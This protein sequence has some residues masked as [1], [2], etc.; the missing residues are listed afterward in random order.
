VTQLTRELLLE[1][2]RD[3]FRPA[4]T[5][6]ER[7]SRR[8]GAELEFIPSSLATG[9]RVQAAAT[10]PNTS[11]MLRRVAKAHRW[12]EMPMGDDPSCWKFDD[13]VITF[14]PGGQ[15]ELSSVPFA[16]VSALVD[17]MRKCTEILVKA[18]AEDEIELKL[19]GIDDCTSIED[20]P[21]QLRRDRYATMTRYFDSIG[22]YGAIMMRQ[23]ASLQI[24]IDKGDDPPSRWRLLNALAP[25]L[26]AMFANSPNYAG[27]AT[28]HKSYRGKVWQLLDSQ[29]TGLAYDPADPAERYLDFALDAPMILGNRSTMFRTFRETLEFGWANL[30]LWNTHLT[31]LFP[32]VRP[33]DHFEIRS[34]DAISTEH[35]AAPLVLITALAY[36]DE[37]SEAATEMLGDPNASLLKPAARYGFTNTSIHECAKKLVEIALEACSRLGESYIS[38]AHADLACKFFEKYTLAGL[39]PADDVEVT[40]KPMR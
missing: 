23:T 30:D 3:L 32:E 9:Q 34:I 26:T 36:D 14:E 25:Y 31:T 35:L 5:L 15:I 39:S 29:R 7:E 37:A 8:V 12:K 33:R 6:E 24:N 1:N 11:E 16:T 22:P 18:A 2:V 40:K 4:K 17:A 20:V 13:G 27:V 38:R 21:L 10:S 28:G 19:L